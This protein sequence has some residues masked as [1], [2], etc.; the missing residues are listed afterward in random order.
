MKIDANKYLE[1][2]KLPNSYR[3]DI[4]R[5]RLHVATDLSENSHVARTTFA[6]VVRGPVARI[7]TGW[8]IATAF[9][10]RSRSSSSPEG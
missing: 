6:I 7:V 3:V 9:S 1:R 4:D 2:S 10:K 8:R 5:K